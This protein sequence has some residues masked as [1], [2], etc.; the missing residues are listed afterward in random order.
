MSEVY[1]R[2]KIEIVPCNLCQSEQWKTILA[3]FGLSIVRCRRCGLVYA[4]PRLI[5]S[6]LR[7]RYGAAYFFG[8]YLPVFRADAFSYSLDVIKDHYSLHLSILGKYFLPGKRLLDIGCGAGFFLKAA[9]LAGWSVAGTET[10]EAASD[11]ARAVT[12]VKVFYGKLEEIRLAPESFDAVTMLDILEH[13]P[14]PMGTLKEVHRVLKKGGILIVNTPD[15]QS[16]SRV[17]LGKGWAVLSPVE[18]LFYFNEKTLRRALEQAGFRVIGLRNLLIFIPEYTHRRRSIRASLWRSVIKRLEKTRLVEDIHRYEHFDLV[19][20]GDDE[21]SNPL[22]A[23]IHHKLKK[24]I[25]RKAKAWLRG[26]HL[27]AVCQ[28]D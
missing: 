14:D 2:E 3:K 26:D 20:A 24:R 12:K 28:K 11:Y 22:V 25:Y 4:S 8:E 1:S 10:S 6:E 16:L 19:F 13:L 17:F 21:A 18:H 15:Y 9:E 5:E 7:K 27:V 23:E